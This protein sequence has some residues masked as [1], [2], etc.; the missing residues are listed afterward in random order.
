MRTTILSAAALS[1]AVTALLLT[2]ARRD[3]VSYRRTA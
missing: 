1:V 2:V 3:L